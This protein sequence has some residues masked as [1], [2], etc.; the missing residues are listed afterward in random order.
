MQLSDWLYDNTDQTDRI[1]LA[2]LFKL[3][4]QAGSNALKIDEE[5]LASTLTQDFDRSPLKGRP[6]FR[7]SAAKESAATFAARQSRH[8]EE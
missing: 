1:Q 4:F 2:R 3:L 6:G 7:L 5:S 8:A